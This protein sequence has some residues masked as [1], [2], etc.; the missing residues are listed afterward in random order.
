M[1]KNRIFIIEFITGGGFNQV[2]IPD[3]LFAEGYGMLRS[4]VADFKNL[5]YEIETFIDSRIAL[6]SRYIEADFINIIHK[7]DK[8]FKK[9]KDCV[10][11]NEFCF[12][13]AP[14]FSKIL[15]SLTNTLSIV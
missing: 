11:K 10:R 7:S 5:D 2:E 3:S 12:I 15:Y 8:F 9:F 1:K 6:L 13:I 4:I 14:E